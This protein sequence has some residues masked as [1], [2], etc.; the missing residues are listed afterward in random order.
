MIDKRK[1]DKKNSGE[2]IWGEKLQESEEKSELTDTGRR[3]RRAILDAI[4]EISLI[5]GRTP[6]RYEWGKRQTL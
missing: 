4:S 1:I 6:R 2:I 5:D 3:M